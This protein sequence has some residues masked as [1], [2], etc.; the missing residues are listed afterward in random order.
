[1]KSVTER[2]TLPKCEIGLSIFPLTSKIGTTFRARLE[3]DLRQ[4][5]AGNQFAVHY[6]P[7][8]ELGGGTEVGF[9]ALVRW[10]HPQKGMVSPAAFI[11]IAESS[12]V[13]VPIG[14][15]VLEQSCALAATWRKNISVAV[16]ISPPSSSPE[17]WWTWFPPHSENMALPPTGW[18]LKSP[19][20]CFW[21]NPPRP[22]MF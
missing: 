17:N 8:M 1:M 11:P 5:L 12:G 16:N 18:S 10:N 7:L 3:R 22:W 20:L 4:A 15:W 6:Q 13:I 9:E 14:N 21:K 19:S 2:G